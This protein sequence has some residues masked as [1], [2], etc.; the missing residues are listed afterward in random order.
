MRQLA[1]LSA[2]AEQGSLHRAAAAQ[3]MSQPALSKIVKEIEDA[4]GAALFERSPTGLHPTRLGERLIF[5]ARSLLADLDQLAFELAAIKEG[6]GSSLRVGIIQL[7]S[8]TLLANTIERLERE[9]RRYAFQITVGSTDL[10][11]GALRAHTLDC[12]LA[13]F[14]GAA[15]ADELDC[16]ALY[17]QKSCLVTHAKGT[18]KG[19]RGPVAL[20]DLNHCAWIL[21]PHPT[22]TRKALDRMFLL[23]D[24]APPVPAFECF[25]PAAIGA[26][27]ASRRDLVAI[28]PQEIAEDLSTD[29]QLVFLPIEAKFSLPE[30]CLIKLRS[31]REDPALTHFSA[32]LGQA[33]QARSR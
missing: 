4:I 17:V 30:I 23:A 26:L 27:L 6:Y 13:R 24:L 14:P 9:E 16:R 25:D 28:L 5:R 2:I 21:P 1:V 32:A 10:L 33:I 8:P 11:I 15:F 19:R 29:G 22:P 20:S 31:A 7:L 18:L 12:V 3:G